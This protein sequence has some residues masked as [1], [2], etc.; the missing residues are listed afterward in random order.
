MPNRIICGAGEK[1]IFV[2]ELI[3]A[4]TLFHKVS[5]FGAALPYVVG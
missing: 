4:A 2:I 3:K 5:N 1:E